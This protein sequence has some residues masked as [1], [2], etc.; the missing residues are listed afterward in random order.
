MECNFA[1]L[2]NYF[3]IAVTV[4]F[5]LLCSR[6]AQ[7]DRSWIGVRPNHEVVLQLLLIPVEHQIDAAINACVPDPLVS[8]HVCIPF[9]GIVP[10]EVVRRAR[11]RSAPGH[12]DRGICSCQLHANNVGLYWNV[13]A[14]SGAVPCSVATPAQREHRFGVCE[15]ERI[16]VSV[17]QKPHLRIALSLICLETQ[18]KFAV[19]ADLSWPYTRAA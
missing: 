7:P 9:R 12:S 8:P 16:P 1:V 3:E 6:K 18:W 17:R 15:K 5:Q 11:Q 2:R 4:Q 13:R 14:V 19:I 10:D